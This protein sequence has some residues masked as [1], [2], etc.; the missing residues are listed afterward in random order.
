MG[1]TCGTVGTVKIEIFGLL[2]D[3]SELYV[4]LMVMH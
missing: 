4:V 1:D 3:R 2:D